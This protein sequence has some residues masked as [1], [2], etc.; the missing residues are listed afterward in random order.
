[1]LNGHKPGSFI[2]NYRRAR[3][4]MLLK[5]LES[6]EAPVKILDIGGVHHFWTAMDLSE[7]PEFHVTFL[8]QWPAS[9]KSELPNSVYSKGDGRS[10]PQFED[11][12][13]DIAFS[14]SVIEHVG[15]LRDQKRMAEE[16]HRVGKSFFVQ[17]P[18]RHFPI[19][20]HFFLPYFQYYPLKLR[21]F[22][23]SRFKLGWWE[24]AE[25]YHEAMEE[26]ESIRL[27]N[28][29]EFNYL[30]PDATVSKEKFMGL[31]KSFIAVS[32]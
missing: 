5:L 24:K 26:V 23:H 8:N 3:F 11:N 27:I 20:A 32:D 25:G 29:S 6:H 14:N 10:M 1:M 18:N 17:T 21:A 9:T 22:L 4:S 16:V 2:N 19:E 12:Q 30:F 13:F 31:T 15:G 28:K 7:M